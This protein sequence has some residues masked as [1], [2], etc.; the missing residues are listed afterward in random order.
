MEL[1]ARIRIADLIAERY[2]KSSVGS[3]KSKEDAFVVAMKGQ[4]LGLELMQSFDSIDLIHGN[5]FIRAQALHALVMM[6]GAAIFFEEESRT[7][8]SVTWVTKRHGGS[9][10]T[11]T[12]SLADAKRMGL[13]GKDNWK[14]DPL[15]MCA[16]RAKA[17]LARSVYPDVTMGMYTTEEAEEID[18]GPFEAELIRDDVP[19]ETPA[20]PPGKLEAMVA[21]MSSQE[22]PG[23]GDTARAEEA[24][25]MEPTSEASPE[26][27]IL[28]DDPPEPLAEAKPLTEDQREQLLNAVRE[29][30]EQLNAMGQQVVSSSAEDALERFCQ[31]TYGASFD[32]VDASKFSDILEWVG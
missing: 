18:H 3:I 28:L 30:L 6:S 7:E 4:E 27:G 14:K 21:Q 29:R 13:L 20:H 19:S 10:Q 32:Q 8:D 11:A 17:R 12:F 1:E 5:P 2:A 25:A 15:G 9:E 22:D 26:P 16:N 23:E 31:A 24:P